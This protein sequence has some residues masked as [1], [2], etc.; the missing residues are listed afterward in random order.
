MLYN[1]SYMSGFGGSRMNRQEANK[2]LSKSKT[3]LQRAEQQ[4]TE[5]EALNRNVEIEKDWADRSERHLERMRNGYSEGAKLYYDSFKTRAT[6][7]TGCILVILALSGGVLPTNKAYIP[8]LWVSCT[9][10]LFSIIASLKTME[11]VTT[12]VF[13]LLTRSH[14]INRN[15]W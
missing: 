4:K 7:T 13:T 6:I 3:E 14:L 12:N 11:G 8:I 2:K 15:E 9:L 10:L 1:L 5:L